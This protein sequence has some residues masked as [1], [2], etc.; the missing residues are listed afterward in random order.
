MGG[1]AFGKAIEVILDSCPAGLKFNISD[2]HTE[3]RRQAPG[4]SAYTSPRLEKDITEIL[5]GIFEGKTTGTPIS[6]IIYN[7]DA[8]SS[9]YDPIKNL[10]RPGHSNFTYLEKYGIFDY[11]GR[12]QSYARETAC[13]NCTRIDRHGHCDPRNNT[14]VRSS[15]ERLC[16]YLWI[17]DVY[18]S[19]LDQQNR[20]HLEK[21]S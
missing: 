10:L 21:E 12:G 19:G 6:I 1:G 7:E 17:F 2:I 15:Y 5:S 13:R 20:W 3:L 14:F 4:Q 18:S 16:V 9:K 11:R 8:D